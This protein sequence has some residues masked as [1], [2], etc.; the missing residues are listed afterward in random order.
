MKRSTF[1]ALFAAVSFWV[2][3]AAHAVLIHFETSLSGATENP[4]VV[5]PG[6]GTA[7]VDIDT[8]SLMRM[9]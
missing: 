6:N 4:A 5:T 1:S 3:S 2:A 9:L 8:V 7:S